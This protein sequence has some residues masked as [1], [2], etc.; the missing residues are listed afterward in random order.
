VRSIETEITIRGTADEV[1]AVLT[2][3]PR[4]PD[5]NPFIRE[6]SGEVVT[7]SRLS[8]RI[9]PPG[10]KAMAFQ[11]RVRVVAPARELRWLGHLLFP[12]L[13]DGEH[14]FRI[15]PLP[16]E[17]VRFLQSERFRGVLVALLP[18]SMYQNTQRGFEQMNR[19]LKER[20]E[21]PK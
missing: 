5:W 9:Q 2:D 3:F 4:Y 13:F 7:G 12:G 21:G 15:D 17:E 14:M 8:V 6:A 10:G 16:N 1:W 20:V 11:P 18:A 19:A